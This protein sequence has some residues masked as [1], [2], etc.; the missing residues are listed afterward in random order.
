M[1]FYLEIWDFETHHFSAVFNSVKN[2]R[3][4]LDLKSIEILE[5]F[6]GVFVL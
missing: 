5:S 4:N 1:R 2:G 3:H 6:D